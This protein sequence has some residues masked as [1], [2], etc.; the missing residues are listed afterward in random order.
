LHTFLEVVRWLTSGAHWQGSD[1]IPVRTLEH[2]ELT[3]AAL[4]LATVVALPLGLLIGHTGRGELLAVSVA[5]LGRA[6]PSFAILV[7]SFSLVLTLAPKLAFGFLPT[8]AALFL[9]AIPPIL[10]NTY[11]GVQQVERDTVEAA[12][13]MGMSERQVLFG[14]E[15]PLAA[16]V[17][18]A[19]LRTAALQVVATATLSALIA[20]GTLGRYIVDGFATSDQV[21][22]VAGAVLIAVLALLVELGFATLE[23]AVRPRTTST[24]SR[25]RKL[26]GEP[27]VAEPLVRPAA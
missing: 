6:I 18:M 13:G 26:G 20:G 15:L 8:L 14:L 7:I 23:R 9:L 24:G 2:L 12:R 17:I 27:G 11:V 16:P 1:G 19:G 10:T 22:T 25:P 5:N 21:E 3:F 4:A